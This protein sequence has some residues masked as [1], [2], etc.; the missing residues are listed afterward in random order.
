M[1]SPSLQAESRLAAALQSF[2]Q[3]AG[4]ENTEANSTSLRDEEGRAWERVA[5]LSIGGGDEVRYDSGLRTFH[6]RSKAVVSRG[7][8][9]HYAVITG[10]QRGRPAETSGGGSHGSEGH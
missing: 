1:P 7:P 3:R 10:K 6:H 8:A 2:L 9:L 4:M 5:L